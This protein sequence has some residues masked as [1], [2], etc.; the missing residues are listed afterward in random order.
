MTEFAKGAGN[1]CPY[2]NVVN[3]NRK[4]RKASYL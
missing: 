1:M 4:G 3:R 2:S